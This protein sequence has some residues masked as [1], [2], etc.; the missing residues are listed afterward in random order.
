MHYPLFSAVGADGF[1]A[2]QIEHSR[3]ISYIVLPLMLTELA[4]AAL[5]VIVPPVAVASP[6]LWAGLALVV[7]IWLSTFALQVP[8]HTILSG[9]F[10][11]RAHRLLVGTNWLRTIAWSARGLLVLWLAARA[12]G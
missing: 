6:L 9:G 5:F 3:R 8:Q 4:T 2:Y 10:D 1:A 11:G 7:L 12:I